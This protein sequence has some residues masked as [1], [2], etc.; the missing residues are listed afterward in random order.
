MGPRL[1]HRLGIR[2]GAN[3]N[4]RQSQRFVASCLQRIHPSLR[5]ACRSGDDNAHGRQR[6][7]VGALGAQLGGHRFAQQIGSVA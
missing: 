5:I 4:Q 2:D 7:L 3:F 6:G 1:H